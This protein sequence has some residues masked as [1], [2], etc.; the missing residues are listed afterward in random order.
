[1]RDSKSNYAKI[2]GPLCLR[3]M[4]VN[5]L[6]DWHTHTLAQINFALCIRNTNLVARNGSSLRSF[7]L[8]LTFLF[9]SQRNLYIGSG[10]LH[11]VSKFCVN[12]NVL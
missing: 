1:M 9:N 10:C 8:L 5:Y 2:A 6:A 3:L 11:G 12:G 7:V 4:I